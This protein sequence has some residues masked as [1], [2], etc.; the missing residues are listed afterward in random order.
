MLSIDGAF[1]LFAYLSLH[2]DRRIGRFAGTQKE[3][4]ARLKVAVPI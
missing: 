4:A 1:N 2:A 3:L